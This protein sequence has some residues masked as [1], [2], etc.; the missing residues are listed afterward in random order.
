MENESLFRA[1]FDKASNK[2]ITT[3]VTLNLYLK[4]EDQEV[5]YGEIEHIH[6]QT[7]KWRTSYTG[8][9]NKDEAKRYIESIGNKI[10][11]EKKLNIWASNKYFDDK[12]NEYKKSNFKE[13]QEL[14][15]LKQNDWLKDDII[16][17]GNDIYQRLLEFFK[18]NV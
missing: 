17:R 16:K 12:K 11:L 6:P 3:L 1:Q 15:E 4:Y 14:A 18:K 2:L 8:W 13:A 9:E 5:I 10:W 7:T